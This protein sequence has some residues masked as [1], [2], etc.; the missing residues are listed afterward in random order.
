MTKLR[1]CDISFKLIRLVIKL[2]FVVL[3]RVSSCGNAVGENLSLKSGT[4]QSGCNLAR[5]QL[6]ATGSKYQTTLRLLLDS[7]LYLNYQ[8]NAKLNLIKYFTSLTC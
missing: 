8:K 2:I 5:K 6:L 1:G 4:S 7:G 3:T